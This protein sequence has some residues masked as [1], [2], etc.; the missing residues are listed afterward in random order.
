MTPPRRAVAMKIFGLQFDIAWENQAGN[1]G[2]IARLVDQ[3]E[4]DKDSLIVLPEMCTTGFTMDASAGGVRSETRAALSGLA[5]KHSIYLLAGLARREPDA[6][7]AVV[8]APDGGEIACYRKQRPFT[9]GGEDRVY[10]AGDGYVLFDWEGCRV[11]PF[12]CYDLRF[13]E[14]FRPAAAA[15][16]ELIAVIASWPAKRV[17]HWVKLLQARA[18]ENQCH[19][20]GVNRIGADPYNH[21][22]GRSLI[23]DPMGEILADADEAEGFISAEL[24]LGSQRKLREN[25]PFL[26]DLR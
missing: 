6:N 24:D 4:P 1:C 5:R 9:M 8:F 16:A 7:E 19:V 25:L 26:R 2:Q 13:P 14:L 11:A 12:I 23:I 21:H 22:N 20:I 15:G 10:E 3:A 18:I 17:I